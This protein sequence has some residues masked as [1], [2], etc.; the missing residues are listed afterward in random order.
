MAYNYLG[1]V[2]DVAGR[3]NETPLAGSNFEV[4][5]GF[6]TTIREAI[7]TAVRDINQ[8][9]FQWPFNHQKET[10][11][12]EAGVMRY[13]APPNMKYVDYSTFRLRRDES[14]SV[15]R[16][17]PLKELSYSE[18]L[19]RFADE[20]YETDTSKGEQPSYVTQT[21]D[22]E[23][24]FAPM[25]DKAYEVDYEYYSYP[26]DLIEATD[27]P[28]IP[29]RFRNVIIDGAM[30]HCYMF[31]DNVEQAGMAFNRFESGLKQMRLLLITD[32][33]YFRGV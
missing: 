29:E 6:Y 32:S 2:N 14:L 23:I 33:A 28:N 25:P 7:N 21:P 24:A 1:L 26:V 16:G 22:G 8:R 27:V 5:T 31:R 10:L 18:Y 4:A 15:A 9:H 13:A 30:Y 11:D 20:E 12:M 17:R 19:S 3:L